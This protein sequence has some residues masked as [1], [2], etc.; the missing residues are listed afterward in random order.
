MKLLKPAHTLT[1]WKV[2][3]DE[4]AAELI[5]A[6]KLQREI[7]DVPMEYLTTRDIE[8]LLSQGQPIF[9][10]WKGQKIMVAYRDGHFV[11][12]EVEERKPEP[13]RSVFVKAREFFKTLFT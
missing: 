11:G 9:C 8:R 2:L 10:V 13:P 4:E 7:P 3:S 1:Q 12:Y 5:G 6:G